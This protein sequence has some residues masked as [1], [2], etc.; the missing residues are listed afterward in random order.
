MQIAYAAAKGLRPEVPSFCPEDYA[1]MFKS[2]KSSVVCSQPLMA[3]L[4]EGCWSANPD[5]RPSFQ[6]ILTSL[7]EMKQRYS[8]NNDAE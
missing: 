3:A 8:G 7:F 6:E 4:M 5:D 2:L 1:G